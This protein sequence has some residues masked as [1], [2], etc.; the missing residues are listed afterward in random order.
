[1]VAALRCR[2]VVGGVTFQRAPKELIV[3]PGDEKQ[4]EGGNAEID[5][6]CWERIS[7]LEP[8]KKRIMVLKDDKADVNGYK[9]CGSK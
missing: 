7:L 2:S 9:S 6:Y 5:T 3:R 4:I 8:V 1:M